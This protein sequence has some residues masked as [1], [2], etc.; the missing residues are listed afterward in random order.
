MGRRKSG[1]RESEEGGERRS[2][3]GDGKGRGELR[4][5]EGKRIGGGR[6]LPTIPKT[7]C[8]VREGESRQAC[9][10]RK[11]EARMLYMEGRLNKVACK[12]RM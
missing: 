3:C 5:L 1:E 7:R 9:G 11:A 2:G 4:E 12:G 6:K 8:W 10:K